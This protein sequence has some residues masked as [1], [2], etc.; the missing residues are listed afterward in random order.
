MQ[1][2]RSWLAIALIAGSAVACS[3]TPAATQG[4]G[5]GGA[6]PAPQA[7]PGGQATSPPDGSGGTGGGSG[8]IHI[9]IG[10]PIQMTVDE[11]F[12][13]I[14]SRFTGPAGVALNFT[15]PGSTAIAAVTGVNETWVISYVSDQLGANSQSCQL[16]NWNI[17]ATSG[18]GSFDCKDGFATKMDGTFLSGITMKGSFE[19][20]Q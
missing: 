15:T 9:E 13:L 3:G 1:V 4:P 11:P 12:L 5:G 8:Q 19:A 18:S 20:S 17:G 7:T 16:S 10:G 2:Q 6:T 14:G